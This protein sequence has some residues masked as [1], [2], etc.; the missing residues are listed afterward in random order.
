MG[1]VGPPGDHCDECDDLLLPP[2]YS[3]IVNNFKYTNF[4][5]ENVTDQFYQSSLYLTWGQN[6]A[7]QS[8]FVINF[9]FTFQLHFQLTGIDGSHWWWAYSGCHFELF[10]SWQAKYHNKP[11]EYTVYNHQ[12]IILSNYKRAKNWPRS[13]VTINWP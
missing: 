11:T 8:E 5:I 13:L 4:G 3:R 7:D 12:I 10:V 6:S 9:L 1:R 2:D